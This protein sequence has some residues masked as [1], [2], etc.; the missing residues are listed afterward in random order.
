MKR[1]TDC[2]NSEWRFSPASLVTHEML[3]FGN[4]NWISGE[5]EVWSKAG[6]HGIS[7]P[8]NTF[9]DKWRTVSL[10]HDF[11]LEGEFTSDLPTKNGGLR[12]G[13]AWYVKKFVLPENDRGHRIS[14]EFDGVYRDCSVF[15]NGHF[16]GRHLSGYTSFAFDITDV[17]TFGGTNAIAV[18]VDATL[19]ELW[20][21]EGGGIYRGVRLVKSDLVH[22]PQ[23]GVCVRTGGADDPG[24]ADAEVTIRNSTYADVLAEIHCRIID[25]AGVEVARAQ[26]PVSVPLLCDAVKPVALSVK[27]PQ[28]WNLEEPTLYTMEVNVCVDGKTVDTYQQAFGFRFIRFDP[29][30]GFHLNGKPLKIKGTGCHQD[31]GCVGVAVPPAL[32]AW[33]V[34]KLKSFGCNALRTS[35]VPAD[36]ALLDSCDR[37]GMLVMT[38]IRSPGISREQREDMA[39]LV[40]RDRNHPSVILWSLGNEEFKLQGTEWGVNIFRRLQHIAHQLDPTRPTTYALVGDWFAISEFYDRKGFRFDVF[41]ANYRCGEGSQCYDDFHQKYPDTPILGSETWGG[42]CSRGL[43]GEDNCPIAKR[44]LED[45]LSRCWGDDRRYI[46]AYANWTTP[47]GYSIEEMWQDCAGRPFMAGT[48]I[49]TGFDYRGETTP[50]LWPS[51]ITRF[52]VIDLCG[53][54]KPVAHYLRSWWRPNDPHIFVMP[55][56]NWEGNEGK[57]IDVRCYANTAE[58]ELLLNGESLGRKA[59]PVNGRLDWQVSYASGELTAVGFDAEGKEVSRVLNRTAG[60]SAAVRLECERVDNILVVN[61]SIV[62]AHGTVCPLADNEV[63]FTCDGVARLLGVGNG[64]PLSHEPDQGTNR[65]KAYHGLC[66]AIYQTEGPGDVSILGTSP[67]LDSGAT[68]ISLAKNPSGLPQN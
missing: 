35:I 26:T 44:W 39:D 57:S 54:Y 28:L 46:S 60:P 45:K 8:A 19:D 64:N 37:L 33:R 32:Q 11:V 53:F 51:V 5:V 29:D 43:Y 18:Y 52:G 62:D 42:T 24:K 4:P 68:K 59:M 55:H 10:P 56:W 17:C 25:R 23:W 61:A 6:N 58:V 40:R 1:S 38:E 7:N 49:W 21:Y 67:H 36:P 13:R 50:Y 22:V 31:S 63:T 20:S 66:Q 34:M 15:F 2:F 12:G 47:W 30:T 9:V 27:S 65:R 41:G 14:I 16:V 48:F 3:C